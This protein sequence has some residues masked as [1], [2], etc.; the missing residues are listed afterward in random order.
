MPDAA[1][2]AA[3]HA[4]CFT[5]PR[6]WSA[7]EIADLLTSAHVFALGDSCGFLIGRAVAGEAELLTLAVDPQ[8]R[9]QGLG[10]HLVHRFFESARARGAKE[11][12]LEVS[13]A[14]P[15]AIALYHRAG[16]ALAGQRRGYY[17][18][19]DGE[20]IDALILTRPL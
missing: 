16:F 11:A 20:K 10:L 19:P 8:A 15:A 3:L 17:T 5:T 13:A 12:F 18:T 9:R 2:W 1:Q 14:N 7:A 4:A 6:P